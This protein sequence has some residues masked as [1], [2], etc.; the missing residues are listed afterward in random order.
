M[1]KIHLLSAF[2]LVGCLS[3]EDDMSIEGYALDEDQLSLTS[4]AQEGD[5][6]ATPQRDPASEVV[7][8]FHP[9]FRAAIDARLGRTSA[10]VLRVANAARVSH[11]VECL[12]VSGYSASVADI[13]ALVVT[14]PLATTTGLDAAIETVTAG[15]TDVERLGIPEQHL[16]ACLT[17]AESRINPELAL[18]ELLEGATIEISERLE[19][20]PTM[21]A[22]FDQQSA[23]IASTG[24]RGDDVQRFNDEE[25]MASEITFGFL[26]GD[27]SQD[28]ALEELEELQAQR[29]ARQ[30]L[31]RAVERCVGQRLAVERVLVA[32]EQRAYLEAHP[33]WADEVTA[34]Y[35]QVL[36]TFAE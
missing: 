16:V 20:D 32:E 4:K 36:T 27:V 31:T 13:E 11:S 18:S 29:T 24:F 5:P 1:N 28:D 17:D 19:A 9:P 6:A 22:A 8:E 26:T 33:G 10:D 2:L 34:S 25:S 21:Q 7:A 15:Q 23:C 35:R 30:G 3:Q 12:Q 14:D